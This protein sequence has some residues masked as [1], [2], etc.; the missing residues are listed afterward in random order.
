MSNQM[1]ISFPGGKRVQASYDGFELPTDQTVKDG[2]EASAP[3][4]YDLFLASLGTCAGLYVLRFCE[5]RGIPHQDIR[6]VQSWD[7]DK[8]RKIVAIK[9][10][11]EVPETFPEKYHSALIRAANQC[12]VKKTIESPPE[13]LVRTVVG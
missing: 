11:I 5:K 6:I 9:L 2:G 3:A 1:T 12:T 7:R 13:F 4:P 8:N 10:D